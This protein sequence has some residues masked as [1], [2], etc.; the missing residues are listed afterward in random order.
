M[1]LGVRLIQL[2]DRAVHTDEAVNAVIVADGL[3]GG[4]YHYDPRDRHGPAFYYLEAPL[5]R[6]LGVRGLADMEAGELRAGSALVSAATVL[7][8]GLLPEAAPGAI[9]AAALI[10]GLGAPFV[11]YGRYALHE[12]I[13]IFGTLLLLGA[14]WRCWSEGRWRWAVLAG[15]GLGIAACA[16][17]SA[18]CDLRRDRPRARPVLAWPASTRRLW[19]A[20]RAGIASPPETRSGR[21][22]RRRG[23]VALLTVLAGYSSMGRNP[24]GLLD[25]LRAVPLSLA[26]A[27]GQGHQ[28]PWWTYLAWLAKPTPLGLPWCGWLVLG[29]GSFGAARSFSP[30]SDAPLMRFFAVLGALLFIIY[31][32]TPYKTPW[33]MLNFLAPMSV[34]AGYG[35]ARS[36]NSREGRVCWPGAAF[37][38]CLAAGLLARES[39]RLCFRYPDEPLNPYS[40]SPTSPDLNRLDARLD[41][42]GRHNGPRAQPDHPGGGAR[43]LAAALVLAKISARGI[44]ESPAPAIVRRCDHQLVGRGPGRGDDAG[45]RLAARALRPAGRHP[46]PALHPRG[47]AAWLIRFTFF[48]ITRWRPTLKCASP[49]ARPPTPGQAAQAAFAIIDRTETRLS[50][51][52]E[53]SEISQINR[54]Q[55]GEVL[56]VSMEVAACLTQA[57]ELQALTRGGL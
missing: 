19:A 23:F 46:D 11:F 30:R 51:F 15:L 12:P 35:L 7:L 9:L 43:L 5:C 52:L 33:L 16:K 55:P 22:R 8:L 21:G 18:A 56:P 24:A 17:E 50:R 57:L 42:A 26:R 4:V 38:A 45:H 2:D 34:V 3:A 41:R 39:D 28:K 31:A 48:A 54:L 27:T 6:L 14:G 1:A 29:C 10:F 53:G 20:H 47:S 44:L 49:G 36:W 37:A 32:A 13:L 40:Y 25:V